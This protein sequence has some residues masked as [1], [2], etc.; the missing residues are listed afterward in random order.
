MPLTQP[1]HFD[2]QPATHTHLYTMKTQFENLL[3]DLREELSANAYTKS[4]LKRFNG[5]VKQTDKALLALK[6]YLE[7]E[8]LTE[9]DEISI[10]KDVKPQIDAHRIEEG[11]RFSVLNYKPMGTVKAQIKYLDEELVALQSVF[12]RNAFYYQYYKNGFDELDHLFFLRGA[13]NL[14]LPIPEIFDV[15]RDFSTPVSCLYS[16][17]MGFERVQMFILKEIDK[18]KPASVPGSHNDKDVDKLK[19]TGEVINII[20][21]A[22]G[23]WLT[24][25]LN[26]GNATLSQIVRW[27][28]SQLDVDL[29][30]VQKRFT[31]MERRKR[32]STTK[33]LDQMS[34]AVKQKL[35]QGNQ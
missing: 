11:L 30:N 20:E 4:P 18:L 15:E 23:I 13:G 17:F 33:Y 10:F 14:A 31:E 22:Y 8:T 27:L 5:A 34:V 2:F 9:Q 32:I 7:S 25:Q 35:E 16:K 26:N 24:G 28:E 19:W 29:G 12:R 1:F 3:N 21:V 6:N